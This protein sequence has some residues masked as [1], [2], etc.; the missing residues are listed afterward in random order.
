MRV[1]IVMGVPPNGWFIRDNPTK[2]DDDWGYPYFRTPPN[3]DES[4]ASTL[5]QVYIDC[6]TPLFPVTS[7]SSAFHVV[8]FATSKKV[9][10]TRKN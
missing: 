7:R 1:S 10:F 2:M 5:D 6:I 8:L 9:I 4:A 3:V